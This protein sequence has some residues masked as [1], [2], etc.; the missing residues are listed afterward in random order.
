MIKVK[1]KSVEKILITGSSGLLRSNL[2]YHFREREREEVVG[3]HHSHPLRMKGIKSYS[4]DLRKEEE[5]KDFLKTLSPKIIIYCAAI[6]N[7]DWCEDHPEETRRFN[8]GVTE[9]IRLSCPEAYFIYIS[10]DAVYSNLRGPHSEKEEVKPLSV[11]ALTKLEGEKALTAFSHNS[12][13]IRTCIYGINYQEKLSLAEWMWMK[14]SL[15]ERFPGFTD[16]YFSPILVNDLAEIIEM[17][18]DRG[19]TG[20]YNVGSRDHC[21]KYEFGKKITLLGGFPTDLIEPVLSTTC[22]LKAPRPLAPILDVNKVEKEL[23]RRMPNVDEG[24]DRF[25]KLTKDQFQTKL[26]CS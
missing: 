21:S 20:T 4:L 7:L 2:C 5:L 15:S 8:Q 18:I 11:Y 10:T 25:M 3:I 24:L 16:L 13:S 19:L 14:L 26:R 12:L 17:M 6:V 9:T 22:R 1:G 23:D